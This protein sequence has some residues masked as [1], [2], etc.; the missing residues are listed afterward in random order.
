M[1]FAVRIIFHELPVLENMS[2]N[3]LILKP[4]TV[5]PLLTLSVRKVA[6]N[7]RLILTMALV[8]TRLI[9]T[10]ATRLRRFPLESAEK[11]LSFVLPAPENISMSVLIISLSTVTPQ[12]TSSA[13]RVASS[14]RLILSMV[15]VSKRLPRTSATM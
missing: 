1:A 10:S 9:R 2:T 12:L 5:M 7:L 6:N 4:N 15:L 3:V 14:P 13:K 8:N 11:S